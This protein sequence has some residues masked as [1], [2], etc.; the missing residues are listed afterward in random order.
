MTAATIARA[1]MQKHG[2]AA[3][4]RKVATRLAVLRFC[5]DDSRKWSERRALERRIL[6]LDAILIACRRVAV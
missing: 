6:M 3:V 5:Y 4:R 2:R 1:L